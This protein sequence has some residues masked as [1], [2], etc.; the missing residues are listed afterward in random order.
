MRKAPGLQ[1]RAV[2]L[3]DDVPVVI[4]PDAQPEQLLGLLD[5]PAAQLL[6]GQEGRA[7]VR[8]WPLLASFSRI[9]PASV[10]SVLATTASWPL[11][12]S[13][14]LPAQGGDL[15]TAQAAQSVPARA[16]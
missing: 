2:R 10:C 9:A 14:E 15:A 16:G 12:R 7:T 8:A 13:M 3:R 1:R 11:S 4:C 6:D 5:A